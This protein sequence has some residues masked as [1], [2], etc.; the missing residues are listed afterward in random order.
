ML[1]H[2]VRFVC[3]LHGE[4]QAYLFHFSFL[5]WLRDASQESVHIHD[6]DKV[7]EKEKKNVSVSHRDKIP[8]KAKPGAGPQRHYMLMAA[9]VCCVFAFMPVII[10]G[11]KSK[12][13]VNLV[14]QL[15]DDVPL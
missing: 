4:V 12:S 6:E 7:R 3:V 13:W 9:A 10:I 15:F 8:F 1:P 14:L 11:M 2:S 5:F